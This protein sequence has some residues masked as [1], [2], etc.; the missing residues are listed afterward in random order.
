MKKGFTIL[1]TIVSS[2][3]FSQVGINTE[4]PVGVFHIDPK[5]DTNGSVGTGDD[6]VI[7]AAGNVGIGTIAPQAKLD[8][9]GNIVIKDGTEANGRVLVSDSDGVGSWEKIG[10]V[11]LT[12][13]WTL[14][15]TTGQNFPA[16]D[17]PHQLTGTSSL[18][19]ANE[20]ELVLASP[21]ANVVTVPA[22]FYF[23]IVD[24]DLTQI[25]EYGD[26]Q[27][28]IV[29][30]S[31]SI[32]TIYYKEKL[33]GGSFI[34]FFPSNT[35]IEVMAGYRNIINIVGFTRYERNVSGSHLE[36]FITQVRFI[37]LR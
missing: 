25:S 26:F 18:D 15:N 32:Y 1:V 2:I 19:A 21:T 30:Q 3:V 28:R 5:A 34:Y 6:L 7:D 11:G 12:S 31:S 24:H 33:S 17:T 35:T 22:G 13:V 14:Q 4:N 10:S 20:V 27:I 23:I 36:P 9:N 37:R 16:G 29:G 8:I